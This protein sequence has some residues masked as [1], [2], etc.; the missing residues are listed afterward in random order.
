ML[1]YIDCNKKIML[2]LTERHEQKLPCR[3][4]HKHKIDPAA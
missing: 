4:P 3:K 1:C 2:S